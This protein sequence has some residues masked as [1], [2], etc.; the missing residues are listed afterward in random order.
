MRL[1]LLQ[2]ITLDV[3]TITPLFIAGA[4]H[5]YIE[6]EGLRSPTLRGL[7]RWWFRAIMGGMSDEATLREQENKV[8]GSKNT[9]SKVRILTST[10]DKPVSINQL[11]ALTELRYLWFSI[12]MQNA[13]GQRLSCYPPGS[14][15]SITLMS[16]DADALSLA[17]CA[18]WSTIYLGGVGARMR[19]GAGSLKVL[20]ADS[21]ADYCNF[22]F[23]GSKIVPDAANFMS[24]NLKTIFKCFTKLSS[25][26]PTQEPTFCVLSKKTAKLALLSQVNGLFNCYEDGLKAVS[27]VYQQYRGGIR[28]RYGKKQGG[29]PPADRVVFGLPFVFGRPSQRIYTGFRQAS[30]LFI[31]VVKLDTGYAIRLVKFS[32][33][34]HKDFSAKSGLVKRHFDLLDNRLRDRFSETEI[35]I[36][37]V[38]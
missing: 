32:S 18:L 19:R 1:G 33:S 14:K 25:K 17:A 7:M 38:S 11:S 6:G 12:N 20:K 26:K 36:P 16:N 9:R 10:L 8:F 15:F 29:I 13:R 35:A 2:S 21:D 34:I 27:A 5:A 22:L 23:S 4:D 31:G 3:E 24:N 37:E 28:D 30:P